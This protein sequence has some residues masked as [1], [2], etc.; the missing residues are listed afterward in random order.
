VQKEKVIDCNNRQTVFSMQTK[1]NAS[2]QKRKKK[3]SQGGQL[4]SNMDQIQSC[5]SNAKGL[6]NIQMELHIHVSQKL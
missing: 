1:H 6:I 2:N 4:I 5:I 3:S